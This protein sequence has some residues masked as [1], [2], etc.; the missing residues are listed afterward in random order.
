MVSTNNYIY[1]GVNIDHVA[2]LRQAR[3]INYPDPVHAALVAEQ[4][5]ADL[6]T[7]HL[8]EDRRHIQDYDVLALKQQI[9]TRLNLE[10]AVEDSMLDFAIACKPEQCCL[11]PEKREEITTEGGLDVV[12]NYI[13]IKQAVAQLQQAG[14][15]VSL[16]IDHDLEQIRA[17][18]DCGADD[19]EI[20]TGS[21]AMALLHSKHQFAI[22]EEIT[23]AVNLGLELGLRVNAGHGLHYHNV[24][25]LAAIKGIS[26]LNIGHAIISRAVMTGL[27]ESVATMKQLMIQARA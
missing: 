4:A 27:A 19:I 10:I 18:S 21:Y 5:G 22:L 25:P 6:I 7:V 16:F 13:K 8:R 12:K 15:R 24:Q 11:V 2:T 20:H 3:R 14:I 26:E 1:L 9:K 17:A 23:I